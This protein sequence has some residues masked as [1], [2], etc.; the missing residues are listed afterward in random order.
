MASSDDFQICSGFNLGI[1]GYAG[2]HHINEP[3]YKD[4][5]NSPRRRLRDELGYI[6]DELK[7]DGSEDGA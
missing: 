6:G 4:A 2:G 7:E 5:V 3:D 1:S